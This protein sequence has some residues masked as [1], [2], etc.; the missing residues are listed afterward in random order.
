MTRGLLSSVFP[1]SVLAEDGSE[2]LPQ[3]VRPRASAVA[4]AARAVSLMFLRTKSAFLAE[5]VPVTC[6]WWP[7][8]DKCGLY[9][10]RGKSFQAVRPRRARR[11]TTPSPSSWITVTRTIR[12]TTVATMKPVSKRWKP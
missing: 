9:E 8:H 7:K 10:G 11:R 3:A 12:T 1:P 5:Q 2:E 6:W 4:E